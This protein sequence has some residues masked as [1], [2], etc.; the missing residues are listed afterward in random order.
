MDFTFTPEQIKI[1]EEIIEFVNRELASLGSQAESSTNFPAEKWKKC[2][3]FG[4]QGMAAP[5]KYGG[6]QNDIDFLGSVLAM[7]SFGFACRDNG[8]AF[9][10]NA[11]MWTVQLPI[12]YFGNT[13]QKAEF[14]PKFV[15]GRWIGAHALTEPESGSDAF[16]LKTT[17]E[18]SEGGFV[19][20][21]KKRM[22]SLAP[23]ADVALVFANSDPSKAKWGI[24]VFL[25]D[26]SW[27]GVSVSAPI[28]KMGL[29]SIPMGDIEFAECF[30]PKR[31]LIGEVGNGFAISNHSLE[32][33]RCSILASQLGAMERQLDESID[34]VTSRIQFGEK[35]GNFQSVSNRIADMKLRL[36]TARLLL[37]KT[38]WLKQTGKNALLESS[39]LKLHLSECF[40]ESS[41]DAV[42]SR[43]GY[44]YLA[45][46]GVEQDLRDSVGGL[47]YA[48]TSDIQR[49]I[50]A[51]LLGL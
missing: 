15:D 18:K 44:G 38:A 28:E 51:R 43:G 25:V 46:S 24:S 29:D 45:E 14:L 49:N 26:L 21:G 33:E 1:R 2:A 20:N 12:L 32:Y 47:L 10:L 11:Q 50:V 22:I 40:L 16:S 27:E 48:G 23:A 41:L 30:V 4:I 13:E 7:E 17:A 36:E 42:R 39:L 6:R 5:S 31:N 19:L 35:I 9:G 37:Y 8:L 3:E 34:Y